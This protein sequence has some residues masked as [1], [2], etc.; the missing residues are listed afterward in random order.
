MQLSLCR[1]LIGLF[2]LLFINVSVARGQETFV[3]MVQ[4]FG[5]E[6]GAAHVNSKQW[7]SITKR[8][9]SSFSEMF[10]FPVAAGAVREYF[11]V[12]RKGDDVNDCAAGPSFRFWFDVLGKGGHEFVMSRDWGDVNHGTTKWIKIPDNQLQAQA[13]ATRDGISLHYSHYYWHLDARVPSSCPYPTMKIYSIFIAAI[14]KV[15]GTVGT[16]ALNNDPVATVMPRYVFGGLGGS[17][18]SYNGNIGVSHFTPTY[19]LE[20]ASEDFKTLRLWSPNA[21]MIKYSGAYNNGDGA[22]LWQAPEGHVSLNYNSGVSILYARADGNIGMGTFNPQSKLAVNGTITATKVKVTA[23]GWPDYVFKEN[24]PLRSLA[25][26]ETFIKTNQHLPDIPSEKEIT[27][28]G[29]DLGEM[30]KKLL[31]KIEE[32]TLYLIDLKKEN[33]AMK[34]RLDRLER[35]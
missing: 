18:Y 6:E 4:I 21:P 10:P 24:Y 9:Y 20:V 1:R 15:G 17:V 7:E 11:I 2:V 12:I 19:K 5:N 33:T 29:N 22:E 27:A 16:I 31:Q 25:E 28:N 3:N 8:T 14:D 13:I 35:K 32:L 23:T 30:D 34:A 26:V